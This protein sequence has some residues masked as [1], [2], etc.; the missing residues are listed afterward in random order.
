MTLDGM[1]TGVYKGVLEFDRKKFG[2]WKKE[3][4]DLN[5]SIF[6]YDERFKDFIN[7]DK[8]ATF[9]HKDNKSIHLAN[10]FSITYRKKWYEFWKEV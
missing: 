6:P 4:A 2:W 10:K 9:F 8:I 3:I 7:Y 1:K 5:F